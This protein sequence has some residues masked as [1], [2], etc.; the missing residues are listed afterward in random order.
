MGLQWSYYSFGKDKP[1]SI[2]HE[3][4]YFISIG[5]YCTNFIQL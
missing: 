4:A 1:K 5:I 3:K 2:N